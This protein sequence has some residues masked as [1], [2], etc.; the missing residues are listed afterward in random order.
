MTYEYNSFCFIKKE[1]SVELHHGK[2]HSEHFECAL[3]DNKPK[4][5]ENL[6]THLNNCESYVRVMLVIS[7]SKLF[8]VIVKKRI[9]LYV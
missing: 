4:S 2:C 8:Y 3:C 6:N 9:Y 7:E 5:L 1:F